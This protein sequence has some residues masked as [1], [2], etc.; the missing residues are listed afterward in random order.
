MVP[1][2]PFDNLQKH[3]ENSNAFVLLLNA[4]HSIQEAENKNSGPSHVP[5][6]S[7]LNLGMERSS[8]AALP[9]DT[10]GLSQKCVTPRH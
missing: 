9:C 1:V 7:L 5:T 8:A 10:S 2:P 4:R 6:A 3:S